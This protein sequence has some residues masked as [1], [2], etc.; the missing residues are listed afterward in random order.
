MRAGWMEPEG[1]HSV[2]TID[3]RRYH[4]IRIELN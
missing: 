4:A 1:S 3:E 2:E